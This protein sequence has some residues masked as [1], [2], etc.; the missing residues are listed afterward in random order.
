MNNS[1][2]SGA[3]L[4]CRGGVKNVDNTGVTAKAVNAMT[5]IRTIKPSFWTDEKIGKISWGARLLFIAT[6]NLADDE[7]I[8]VWN[9]A[10]LRGQVFPYDI[11]VSVAKI[12]GLMQELIDKKFI[13]KYE[14][15]EE[16]YAFVTHFSRHQVISK[17]MSS[18]K[19]LPTSPNFKAK[20]TKNSSSNTGTLQE[21]SNGE[22]EGNKE[23]ELEGN[24]ELE[25]GNK[26][27]MEKSDN[28]KK[29]AEL[30]KS[31]ILKNNPKAKIPESLNDWIKEFDHMLTIDK[32]TPEEI[33]NVMEFSQKDDFWYTNILSAGSLR[34][35]FDQLY[36][37]S[38]DGGNHNGPT[39]K[40]ANNAFFKKQPDAP[41]P[42]YIDGDAEVQPQKD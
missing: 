41:K 31:L 38:K 3:D 8:L 32:R 39:N 20:Y 42:H 23:L 37:K 18:N 13:E 11:Y 19:P 28:S 7:G 36:L 25:G 15:G 5:R 1:F 6:W 22:L 30:L 35:H 33:E 21:H 12:K 40:L 4:R 17:P 29:F 14:V 10:Y 26:G 34:K 2:T 27:S 9:A 16:V 24:K